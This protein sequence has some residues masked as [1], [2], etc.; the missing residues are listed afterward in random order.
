METSKRFNNAITALVKGFFEGTLFKNSCSACAVGNMVAYS[1][2][3]K[4]D[5]DKGNNWADG[6]MTAWDSVFT[7]SYGKQKFLPDRYVD[8]AKE[9]IDSTGYT[10]DEL[11]KVEFAFETHTKID[12]CDRKHFTQERLMADQF[13]GLMA[14]VDVLMEIEGMDKTVNDYRKLFEYT[15]DFK[16]VSAL[17]PIVNYKKEGELI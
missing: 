8:E 12:W 17:I 7:T 9:Q 10:V 16:P 15:D 3:Y 4:I 13:N 11:A 2:N 14:V 5:N 1:L 6:T